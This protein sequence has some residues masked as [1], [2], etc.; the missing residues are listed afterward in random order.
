MVFCRLWYWDVVYHSAGYPRDA[1]F[2]RQQNDISSERSPAQVF[3]IDMI[4]RQSSYADIPDLANFGRSILEYRNYVILYQE[5]SIL[6]PLSFRHISS[7]NYSVPNQENP[8][9]PRCASASKHGFYP[10]MNWFF[11][12]GMFAH[13]GGVLGESPPK[14]GLCQ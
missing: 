10:R 14:A 4:E 5:P 7:T 1:E 11:G 8:A 3:V 6:S 13:Y 12:T 2:I 9:C